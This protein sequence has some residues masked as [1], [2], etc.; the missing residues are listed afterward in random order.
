M[1]QDKNINI[2]GVN[3]EVVECS[4]KEIFEREEYKGDAEQALLKNAIG[5]DGILFG[6]L[7]N[8]QACTIY[9][10]SEIKNEKKR[11]KILLHEV[12]EA[13]DHEALLGLKHNQIE[14][15][16]GGIFMT[17]R[18]NTNSVMKSIPYAKVSRKRKK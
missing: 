18:F 1:D 11:T 6:G 13:I 14:Q 15:I 16:A 2:L 10:N 5:S 3:Y 9:V 12:M 8:T 7:C 4:P 17:G